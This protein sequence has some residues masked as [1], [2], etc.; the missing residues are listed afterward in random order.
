ML[1]RLNKFLSQS[2]IASRREADK[3]IQEGRIKV[4][5]ELVVSLGSK[6][7]EVEDEVSV[8]GK[9]IERSQD[10]VYIMLNKPPGFLVTLKDPFKRPTIMDLIS[11][12]K[13]RVFPIGRLDLDSRG[14]LLLTNDGELAHRLMHPKFKIKKLYLVKVK[15]RPDQASLSRLKKERDMTNVRSSLDHLRKIATGTDNLMPPILEAV[16][17]Y[18]TLGEICNVLREVFG[19]YRDRR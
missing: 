19:E 2:G 13:S 1:I 18:A 5:D 10:L 7:D 9:V 11:R 14:L 17:N 3:M 15:G 6:I 8:D 16:K 12:I 4:N